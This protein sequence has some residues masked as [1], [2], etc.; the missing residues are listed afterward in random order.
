MDEGCSAAVKEVFIRLYEKGLYR[1]DYIVNWCP[2]CHTTISDIEVE[3]QDTRGNLWYIRYRSK[4]Q[5]RC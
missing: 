2:R 3:H 1:D 5:M 4:I